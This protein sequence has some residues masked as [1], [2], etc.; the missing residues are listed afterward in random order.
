ML[1]NGELC[2]GEDS[3]PVVNP[4]TAEVFAHAPECSQKQLESAIEGAAG[5]FYTW[6]QGIELRR[7]ALKSMAE[8]IQANSDE[9]ALLLTQEQGK[10]LDKAKSEVMTASLQIQFA[11]AAQIPVEVLQDTD[12]ALI[13][14]IHKPYGVVAAITPWNFPISIAFGKVATALIAG[15][16]V[17]LKPSPYTPLSTLKIAEVIKDALPRGVL[18]IISGSD[19]LG[20]KLTEH[21]LI[22]KIDFT[23]SVGTG[24]RV[25]AAAA[26]DLKRFTLELG[27]NDPAIVLADANPK[28]IAKALFWGAFSNSGQV[29]IAVKRV[30]VHESIKE[31]LTQEL[32]KLAEEATVGNGLDA[33]VRLGPIN[34]KAQFERVTSLVEDAKSAGAR[35]V[36]GGQAS[37]EGFCFQ[38]TILTNVDDNARIVKEEQFGPVL[39]ILGFE[40]INDVVSRANSTHFGLGSSIWTE[41]LQQAE[42]LAEHIEAGTTWVNQ[43]LALS[44]LAPFGGTKWSGIGYIGGKWGIEGATELQVINIKRS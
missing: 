10:P 21:P 38:N 17:I 2:N 22:R 19:P 34:N 11:A 44:P 20:A 42:E 23:G 24:K 18:N 4:A 30:Y 5:A 27:G 32:A 39:P 43:H 35:I 29:C 31:S 40:D 14:L 33:G 36:T 7:N 25:A 37:G 15:N 9:I 13:K 12:Q 8:K 3:F 6:K 16:T 26:P 1:I 28:R 41:D